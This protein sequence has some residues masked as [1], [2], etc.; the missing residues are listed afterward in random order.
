MAD[1]KVSALPDAAALSATDLAVVVQGTAATGTKKA[2]LAAIRDWLATVF[3]AKPGAWTTVTAFQNNWTDYGV[4]DT[5]Y[6]RLQYRVVEDRV[7]FRGLLRNTVS[8]A[9]ASAGTVAF[10][11]PAGARPAKNKIMLTLGYFT[12]GST[13]L[14]RVDVTPAGNVLFQ[15]AAGYPGGNGTVEYL[16][17]DGL[18]FVL[19]A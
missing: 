3:A 16:V 1:T 17:L 19:T 15:L 4:T 10:N 6:S 9:S 8:A 12:P 14:S 13:L 18:S 11:L 2:T 7:E 5:N